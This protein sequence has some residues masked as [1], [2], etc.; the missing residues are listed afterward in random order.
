MEQVGPWSNRDVGGYELR[1]VP[2]AVGSIWGMERAILGSAGA[3]AGW[4]IPVQEPPLQ[5]LPFSSGG[6][7]QGSHCE[8]SDFL[9][10]P[11]NLCWGW[12]WDR[13]SRAREGDAPAETSLHRS[14][15]LL[16]TGA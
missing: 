2:S 13:L 8:P 1:R 3:F 6:D 12:Q 4:S 7:A 11:P 15:S 10:W 5:P 16:L 14:A 9:L